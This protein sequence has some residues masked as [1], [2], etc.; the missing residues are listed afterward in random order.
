MSSTIETPVVSEYPSGT[1]LLDSNVGRE[2][3]VA[4]GEDWVQKPTCEG[5]YREMQPIG[6][7]GWWC[8]PCQAFQ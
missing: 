3:D 2:A 5:C 6:R 1:Q 7:G 4:L 8:D